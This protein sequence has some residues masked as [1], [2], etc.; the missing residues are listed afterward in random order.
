[1]PI[2]RLILDVLKP[3]KNPGIE[4]LALALES[5]PGV[6]AVNITVKEFDVDSVTLIVAIEGEDI[7]LN[8]VKEKLDE[9][10]A[11]IHGIDQIVAGKRIIEIPS[12]YIE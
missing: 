10:G 12:Y 4:E 1:M 11:A 9:Y 7:D 6:E 2:K 8:K 5:V 3:L